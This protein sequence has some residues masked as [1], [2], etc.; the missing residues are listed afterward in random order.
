MTQ[1]TP[2]KLRDGSWGAITETEVGV[3]ASITITTR[4]GK[5]WT[6]TVQRVL[7][8]DGAATIVATT[9]GRAAPASR[10]ASRTRTGCSCG[11]I[12]EREQSSDCWTCRHDR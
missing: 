5:S 12:E 8:S 2:K 10:P 3:G 9:T 1:A 11:S 4:S 7:W 6:A